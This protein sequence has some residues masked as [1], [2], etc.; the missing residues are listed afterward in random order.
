[1]GLSCLVVAEKPTLCGSPKQYCATHRTAAP[2]DVEANSPAPGYAIGF[3]AV[4]YP[5]L[6]LGRFKLAALGA[7]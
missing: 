5:L 6:T 2:R 7:L 3:H 1:M 4:S